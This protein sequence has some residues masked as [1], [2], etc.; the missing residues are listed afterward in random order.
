[1][2]WTLCPYCKGTGVLRCTTC[3][4]K[5]VVT[6]ER[7]VFEQRTCTSCGGSGGK[8]VEDQHRDCAP[9]GGSGRRKESVVKVESRPCDS[10]AGKGSRACDRCQRGNVWI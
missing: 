9:C 6:H 1:M 2:P 3:R 8:T 7:R 10:C 4:G 5:R